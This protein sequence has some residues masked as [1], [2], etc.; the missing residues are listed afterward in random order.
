MQPQILSIDDTDEDSTIVSTPSSFSARHSIAGFS[1][2]SKAYSPSDQHSPSPPPS[3]MVSVGQVVVQQPQLVIH[4]PPSEMVARAARPTVI[5]IDKDDASSSDID[6]PA[7][8]GRPKLTKVARVEDAG[9]PAL[10][11]AAVTVTPAPTLA[12]GD[13]SSSIN[14][15]HQ[16][17]V[18][19]EPIAVQLQAIDEEPSSPGPGGSPRHASPAPPERPQSRTLKTASVSIGESSTSGASQ[20]GSSVDKRAASFKN[21]VKH[22]RE[23][24]SESYDP[25][26]VCM[27]SLRVAETTVVLRCSQCNTPLE[28]YDE[29]TI[30]LGVVCLSTFVHRE[31]SLA[32]PYLLKILTAVAK[33][34]NYVYYPWQSERYVLTPFYGPW[35]PSNACPV[36]ATSS[37][38]VTVA[39][40]PDSSS[41]SCYISWHP[42]GSSYSCSRARL[43]VRRL[44]PVTSAAFTSPSPPSD[45]WF[46]KTLSSSLADFQ[47]L[48][49]ATV[50]QTLF[51]VQCQCHPFWSSSRLPWPL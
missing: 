18:V 12:F 4:E 7:R 24:K 50:L 20:G 3:Q 6:S 29:D 1:G 35:H 26:P 30:G 25:P 38:L 21:V 39:V 36:S 42:T 10:T 22:R 23:S 27:G 16:A 2:Q 19:T 46:F 13:S 17:I 49:P 40:W 15:E 41:E 37:S 44:L 5:A 48:N 34:A 11:S 43:E 51:E 47:D 31:P 9:E 8:R 33:V 45:A 32:A 14:L 28:L